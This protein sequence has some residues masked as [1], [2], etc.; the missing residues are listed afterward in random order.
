MVP[1]QLHH[2]QT[3]IHTNK[4]KAIAKASIF[5]CFHLSS[6]AIHFFLY[7]RK[8]KNFAH[9]WRLVSRQVL[10][11]FCLPW[12]PNSSSLDSTPCLCRNI[13]Y[14]PGMIASFQLHPTSL[15]HII[16]NVSPTSSTDTDT[17]LLLPPTCSQVST[18]F[19]CCFLSLHSSP[20][21]IKPKKSLRILH[22]GDPFPLFLIQEKHLRMWILANIQRVSHNFTF[23]LFSFDLIK[24]DMNNNLLEDITLKILIGFDYLLPDFI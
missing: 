10:L 2:T 5:Q 22:L 12:F 17:H 4:N 6:P 14:L 15:S 24:A 11:P 8:R 20:W 23:L 3:Y 9:L 18:F 16:L 7:R 13:L 21:G 19:L 1:T